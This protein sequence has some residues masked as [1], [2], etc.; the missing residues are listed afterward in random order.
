[1][2]DKLLTGDSVSAQRVRYRLYIPN[3][4]WLIN[5]LFGQQLDS[6][7]PEQWEQDGLITPIEAA[8]VMTDTWDSLM[9]DFVQIGLILPYGGAVSPS[10]DLIPCD[11]RALNVADY[12][13]LY[14][15]IGF[16]YSSQSGD[17]FNVPDLR[18]RVMMGVGSGN[19][20]TPRSLGQ[21]LGEETHVLSV[22]ELASHNHANIP[23][24]HTEVTAVATVINGG[25]EAPAASALPSAGSTSFVSV[26]IGYSGDSNAHN[27]VQ[28]TLVCNYLIV[29]R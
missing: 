17:T 7:F 19:G 8:Q 20:L 29:A 6:V 9:P 13:E 23:H 28:P 22:G 5:A 14:D 24:G 1:L 3:E 11:G 15:V 26:D 18:G 21:N 16:T 4:Q 12:P 25:I 10:D 27:N 2:R